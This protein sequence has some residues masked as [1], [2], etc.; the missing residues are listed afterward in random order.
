MLRLDAI[1]LYFTS[2]NG[3]LL[4]TFE[5]AVNRIH[6]AL[7]CVG[8]AERARHDP[9]CSRS[10]PRGHSTCN[11]RQRG[12]TALELITT[13]AIVAILAGI[14]VPSYVEYL[15]RSRLTDGFQAMAQFRTR[16]EQAFQ[17]NGN[18]GV[19]GGPCAVAVPAASAYFSF[20]CTLGAGGASFTMTATGSGFMSGYAYAVDDAGNQNTTAFPGAVVP[21]ACWLTRSGE[22]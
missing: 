7:F 4:H 22:C 19:A 18:Y 5:P 11:A 10:G 1:N 12:F 2:G 15:R 6:A 9:R 14:A 16:M 8:S 13:V 3:D 17:D 20:G 21:V